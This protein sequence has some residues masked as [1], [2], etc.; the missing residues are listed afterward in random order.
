MGGIGINLVLSFVLSD[1]IAEKA[2]KAIPSVPPAICAA[3]VGLL[4]NRGNCQFPH[5]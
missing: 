1:P 3:V 2:P 5:K 4:D